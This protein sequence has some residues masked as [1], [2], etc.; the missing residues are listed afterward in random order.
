LKAKYDDLESSLLT[1]R[2]GTAGRMESFMEDVIRAQL[3]E[4]NRSLL[5]LQAKIQQSNQVFMFIESIAY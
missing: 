2:V 5:R 4:L 1:A 3:L